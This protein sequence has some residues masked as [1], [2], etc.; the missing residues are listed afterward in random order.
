MFGVG[1]SE[2]VVVVVVALL[3]LG[4]EKLPEVARQLGRTLRELRRTADDLQAT[5]H[6]AMYENDAPPPLARAPAQTIAA[7]VEATPIAG[8]RDVPALQALDGAAGAP[9][10]AA[11][12]ALHTPPSGS[13]STPL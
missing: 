9:V 12:A 7:G 11:A 6:E 4:P 2:I 1:L 3:V 13:P 8:T 5:L 10:S